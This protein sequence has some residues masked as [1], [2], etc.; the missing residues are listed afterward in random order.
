MWYTDEFQRQAEAAGLPVIRLR[1]AR[2]IAATI[3]LDSG[4][5]VSAVAKWR[6]H[7]PAVLLRVY[8]HVHPEA[9]EAAGAP[10]F[11]DETEAT[12]T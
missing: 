10:L 5:A 4:A 2:H 12:G 8:G 7:D 6:G 9:L 3:L 1:D 11:G